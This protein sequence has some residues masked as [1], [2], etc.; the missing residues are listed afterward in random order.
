MLLVASNYATSWKE[1]SRVCAISLL[2][3]ITVRMDRREG[4]EEKAHREEEHILHLSFQILFKNQKST[5][6][7]RIQVPY[8]LP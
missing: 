4:E 5:F 6:R 1:S 7:S 3:A 8:S 2:S